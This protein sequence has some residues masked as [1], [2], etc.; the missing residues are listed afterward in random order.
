MAEAGGKRRRG[1][2]DEHGIL[3]RSSA[4]CAPTTS[5]ALVDPT[6]DVSDGERGLPTCSLLDGSIVSD[7]ASDHG[8]PA[9][10]PPS[11]PQPLTP[12]PPPLGNHDLTSV[13][14]HADR[15]LRL[16]PHRAALEDEAWARGWRAAL[17][18]ASLEGKVV[19]D[20]HAG[21]G[22]RSLLAVQAGAKAV[23]AVEPTWLADVC[24][25]NAAANGAGSVVTIIRHAVGRGLTLPTQTVDVILCPWAGPAGLYDSL[26]GSVI[27]ARD[28]FLTASGTI[29]PNRVALGIVG[30]RLSG[31]SIAPTTPTDFVWDDVYGFDMS[32]VAAAMRRQGGQ[33]REV[34]TS[35]Y[36]TLTGRVV[37]HE[38][39]VM[40][41]SAR[42]ATYVADFALDAAHTPDCAG[43]DVDG[44]VVSTTVHFDHCDA[45]VRFDSGAP[46]S[47]LRDVFFTLR[48]PA[49]VTRKS[50]V[51]GA[52]RCACDPSARPSGRTGCTVALTIHGK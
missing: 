5:A 37:L 26:F 52:F 16:G 9:L 14:F 38:L 1:H 31:S 45:N 49:Q 27:W 51:R 19:L 33:S 29:L 13:D 21:L 6:D 32:A 4:G 18:T 47:H 50:C 8:D 30:A 20:L 22:Y 12:R 15:W 2:T 43:V 46:D 25:A 17:S 10:G 3:P 42:D 44:I 24:E 23:Y 11:H 41:C 35:D 34:V 36:E 39:N 40:E 28:R 48:A 7:P